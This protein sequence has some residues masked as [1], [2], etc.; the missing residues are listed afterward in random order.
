VSVVA[1]GGRRPVIVAGSLKRAA[2]K[3]SAPPKYLHSKFLMGR[4]LRLF[5]QKA[6]SGKDWFSPCLAGLRPKNSECQKLQ[7]KKR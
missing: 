4:A 5:D 1:Y 2:K 3:L 6:L 7:G